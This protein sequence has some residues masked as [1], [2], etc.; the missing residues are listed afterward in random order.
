MKALVTGADGMLGVD[1]CAELERQGYIVFATD[2]QIMNVRR[3]SVVSWTIQECA[4]DIVFHLAALTDVDACEREPEEAYRTNAIGT[5]N[6]ALACQTA[7]IPVVYISTISVFDG[8]KNEAYT[9]FDEPNP[10]NIYSCSKY[11][12]E[13]IVQ[14]L[15]H[16]YYIVRAG[17]MFGG[18]RKDKKFVG[19]VLKLAAIPGELQIVDDKFGSPTYTIDFA[20]AAIQLSRTGWYG[21]YHLVNTGVPCS[22]FEYA[23]HILEYAGITTCNLL[24]ISSAH[25]LLPAPRP[26]M[27]AARNLHSD[28]MGMALMRPWKEALREYIGEKL[29]YSQSSPDATADR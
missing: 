19:K 10:Q 20:Q 27:E 5:Q 17:W 9:E 18:G 1:L 6:V 29:C 2:V 3:P 13:K 16:R 26:R 23:Q 8:D 24:S 4:P 7:D 14:R 22:R 12:G 25:F 11:E 15:L 28:L 21:L